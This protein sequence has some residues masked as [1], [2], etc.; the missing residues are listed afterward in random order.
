METVKTERK[1]WE[2]EAR[3]D[4]F[5]SASGRKENE[6]KRKRKSKRERKK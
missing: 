6:I 4:C 2:C 3:L 1:G 5:S